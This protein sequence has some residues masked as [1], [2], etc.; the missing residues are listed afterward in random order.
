MFSS[1]KAS[2]TFPLFAFPVIPHP[3]VPSTYSFYLYNSHL[4]YLVQKTTLEWGS[5]N[6]ETEETAPGHTHRTEAAHRDVKPQSSEAS[7]GA[8]LLSTCGEP[9][10]MVLLTEPSGSHCDN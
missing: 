1:L 5:G 2:L 8:Q 3:S 10:Y 4:F 6:F 7:M 9:R